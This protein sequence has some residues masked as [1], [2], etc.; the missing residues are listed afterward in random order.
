MENVSIDRLLEDAKPLN[1]FASTLLGPFQENSLPRNLDACATS[2]L[3]Q[4]DS[5]A[6][7]PH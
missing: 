7:S 1:V 4:R 2:R 5:R 3:A 6:S